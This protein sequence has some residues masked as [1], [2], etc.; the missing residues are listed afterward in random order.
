M[1]HRKSENRKRQ[2]KQQPTTDKQ[3]PTTV[4]VLMLI[5]RVEIHPNLGLF[6]EFEATWCIYLLFLLP[7]PTDSPVKKAGRYTTWPQIRQKALNLDVY[8]PN[9]S[10]S[11]PYSVKKP[12]KSF[13]VVPVCWVRKVT[14]V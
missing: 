5:C 1:K 9:L 4:T 3:Q 8:P 10:S 14:F 6:D 7:N 13:D 2:Q 11:S 12:L